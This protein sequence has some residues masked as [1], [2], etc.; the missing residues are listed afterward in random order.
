MSKHQCGRYRTHFISNKQHCLTSTLKYEKL[1]TMLSLL[2]QNRTVIE[3]YL[4]HTCI[5][6]LCCPLYSL[7]NPRGYGIAVNK[8]LCICRTFKVVLFSLQTCS[9]LT[10]RN[11]A[12]SLLQQLWAEHQ[13]SSEGVWH[14]LPEAERTVFLTCPPL[15][16][17]QIPDEAGTWLAGHLK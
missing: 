11:C 16:T 6:L 8:L 2:K 12:G 10:R 9:I 7:S 4:K 13:S 1:N 14:C 3:V 15:A 17:E 5:C